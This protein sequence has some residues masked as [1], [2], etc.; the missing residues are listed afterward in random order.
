MAIEGTFRAHQVPLTDFA[1]KP[2][3]IGILEEW[4]RSY[5]PDELFDAN[6]TFRADLRELAPQGER[7]MGANP[8]RQRR[9]AAQGPVHAGL[10][11]VCRGGAASPGAVTGEATRVLGTCCAT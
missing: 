3:H 8:A 9:A 1:A 2:Q 7:R 5:K 4:M 10:P 6:G 11:Q